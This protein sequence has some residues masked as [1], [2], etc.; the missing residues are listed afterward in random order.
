MRGPNSW[1]AEHHQLVAL[2]I[3]PDSSAACAVEVN[4][5]LIKYLAGLHIYS[6][7]RYMV[8]EPPVT[9]MVAPVI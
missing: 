3:K 9:C 7:R 1:S 4:D 2:K 6:Y 8:G 5:Q